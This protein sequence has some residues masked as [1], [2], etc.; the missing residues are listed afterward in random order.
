MVPRE[1]VRPRFGRRD[2]LREHLAEQHGAAAAEKR[3]ELNFSSET[4]KRSIKYTWPNSG[5]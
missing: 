3:I 1:A 5:T 2:Q 4:G